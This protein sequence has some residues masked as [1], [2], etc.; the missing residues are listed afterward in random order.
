[1]SQHTVHGDSAY[2]H[3]D[4]QPHT[5]PLVSQPLVSADLS[6]L[7]GADRVLALLIVLAHRPQGASLEELAEIMAAPKSTV[8]R[9]L[10]SLVKSELVTNSA[11]GRYEISDEF[12]RLAFTYA[13]SRPL[14]QRV[15]PI[16]NRLVARFGE[17]AHYAVLDGNRVIYQAKAEPQGRAVKLT[18]VVGGANPAHATAVGKL[19]LAY[20][21]HT[22]TDLYEILGLTPPS[23]PNTPNTGAAV[24]GEARAAAVTGKAHAAA[25]AHA[26]KAGVASGPA[27]PS[28]GSTPELERRTAHTI[29]SVPKLWKELEIIRAQQYAVDREES[30][31]GLNCLAVPYY[32]PGSQYLAGAISVSAIAFRMPLHVLEEN[33]AEIR[34]IV[35]TSGQ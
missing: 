22:L 9:S 33:V 2:Y 25:P 4:T 21:T 1:M 3:G 5:Q 6:K 12:L 19:L 15:Q 18:S 23:T 27:A 31:N 16:L 24:T 13:E 8:H 35:N 7:K 26:T 30:E 10:S 28:A 17:T 20:K 14:T 32:A 29:T 34:E 11:H